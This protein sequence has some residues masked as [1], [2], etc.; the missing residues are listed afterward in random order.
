[1]K[2]FKTLLVWLML[3]ALPLQG[4]AAASMALCKSG[5]PAQPPAHVH[6][7]GAAGHHAHAPVQAQA[8]G[9]H[10]ASP[11]DMSKC[12]TCAT[13][14][15]GAIMAPAVHQLAL[16]RPAGSQPIPYVSMHVTSHVPCAL[17]RPPHTLIA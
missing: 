5:M 4:Y 2:H 3:L 8:A 6:D 11:S 16:A 15:A 14:C 7:A 9:E 12:S 17:E 1:M 10:C 13:C